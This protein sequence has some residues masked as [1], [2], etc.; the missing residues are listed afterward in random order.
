[1]LP[2][3]RGTGIY[4]P[5]LGL[6]IT[7]ETVGRVFVERVEDRGEGGFSMALE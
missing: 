5:I 4:P 3:G 7:W 2:L 6:L 1:M